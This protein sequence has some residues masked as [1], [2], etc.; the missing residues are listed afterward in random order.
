MVMLNIVSVL[1][2]FVLVALHLGK[3][4]LESNRKLQRTSRISRLNLCI[5]SHKETSFM[6]HAIPNRSHIVVADII[7]IIKQGSNCSIL[8]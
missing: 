2:T 5:S 6:S 3:G 4:R 7:I 8:I 1:P